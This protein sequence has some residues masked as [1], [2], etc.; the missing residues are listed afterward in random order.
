MRIIKKYSNRKLYCTKSKVY[1]T[2]K[3]LDLSS[4]FK[5]IC[6]VTKKDITKLIKA[7]ESYTRALKIIEE[8]LK[9]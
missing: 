7:K 9:L 5:V 1:V 8:E 2:M 4:E 6:N 3:Q